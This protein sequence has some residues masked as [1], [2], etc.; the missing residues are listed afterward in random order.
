M[1]FPPLLRPRWLG[2]HLA[3]IAAVLLCLLFGYW[4]YQ[5][6][7]QPDRETVTNPVEDLAAAE[8]IDTL[9]APGEYMPQD[10]ANEAVTVTGTYDA[11]H[12]LLAP[13]LSPSGQEGYSVV[14]PL[15]TGDGTAVVVNRGWVPADAADADGA[16]PPAPQGEVTVR[17]WLQLPQD[18]AAGGA[19]AAVEEGKVAR[20]SSALLVNEWPYRLYEGYVT[21]GEQTPPTEAGAEAQLEQIPPPDPP[22]EVTWNFRNLSYAAQWWVFGAAAVVFWI[23]RVRRE[24]EERRTAREDGGDGA[25]P[26]AE[27]AQPSAGTAVD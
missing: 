2:I 3:A 19:T 25:A 17:G 8:S 1:R 15:V 18:E 21:L 26:A 13:A 24:L 12:Q 20:I 4:Q 9:L 16:V 6:A 22:Q 10:L 11:E 27:A 7:Q 14:I 23:S 5:R